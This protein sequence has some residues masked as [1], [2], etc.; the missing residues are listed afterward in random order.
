M[1]W[2]HL[3]AFHLCCAFYLYILILHPQ[4]DQFYGGSVVTPYL[5]TQ[6]LPEARALYVSFQTIAK[7]KAHLVVYRALLTRDIS[8]ADELFV[9]QC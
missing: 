9:T 5:S 7:F 4:F 6:F 1:Y 8:L 2:K 3:L